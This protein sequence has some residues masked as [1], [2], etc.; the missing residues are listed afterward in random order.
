MR[1][2]RF[3]PFDDEPVP[4]C[5]RLPLP[6][7]GARDTDGP[8][9]FL[10]AK[11]AGDMSFDP[12]RGNAVR[13][14]W[15]ER[16][17]FS[18]GSVMAVRQVHSR[19]VVTARSPLDLRGAEADGIVTDAPGV[20]VVVTV[21][22]CMPIYL[23]DPDSGAY[24]VLHS[25]WKGTGILRVAVDELARRYGSMPGRLRVTLGPAI[26]SCCY[27]VD[28]DRA[29][30]FRREFGERAAVEADGTWRLDLLAANLA[31]ADDAGIADV[32]AAEACTACDARLG[33]NRREGPGRF[34]RMAA[35]MGRT[36]LP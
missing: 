28:A 32:A 19:R 34:T 1:I 16:A 36:A 7:Q 27:R 14:A 3:D 22:D 13:D 25:G 15:L 12:E 31:L 21:A 9:A 8:R 5:L 17:G 33:S 26:A 20:C 35:A 4:D 24:G 30:A 23:H 18:P 10:S 2:A 29:V 11:A 6:G